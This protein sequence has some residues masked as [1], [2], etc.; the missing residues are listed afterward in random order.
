MHATASSTFLRRVLFL[1]AAS[2][3]ACGLLMSAGAGLLAPWLALPDVLLREAGLVLLPFAAFVA[4][5]ATRP[6]IPRSAVW[7]V[8]AANALWAIDSIVL[9]WTGWVE[10]SLF[11]KAFVVGQAAFVALMAELEFFG[12]RRAAR[13]A[14]AA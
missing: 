10:P 5:V 8:I 2:S 7:V 9:P 4:W 6:A 11:G 13:P 14:L 3:A 12:L 1:D